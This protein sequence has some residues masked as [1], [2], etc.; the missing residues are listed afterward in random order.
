MTNSEQYP[1]VIP[2]GE[3]VIFV[4][5]V[6]LDE[7]TYHFSDK[8]LDRANVITLNV[9][10]FAN[11]RSLTQRTPVK[12]AKTAVS[13]DLFNSYQNNNRDIEMKE[14]ELALLWEIHS[15]LQKVNKNL[16]AGP[17]IVRQIDRYL[18]NLPQGS[19]F[20]RAEAFDM[21]IV[22]RILTKVRG[23]EDQLKTFIGAYDRQTDNIEDS[24]LGE[25]L[26]RYQEVSDFYETTNVL[27]SKAKELKLNGY[28]L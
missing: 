12:K 22:Q 5:T 26:T 1:A 7:S 16:G 10:P 28:T 11:L 27:I 21:Q 4:G 3:N 20:T 18:K 23:P 19:T 24:K 15:E 8:V 13:F 2:I 17:R 14:N 6:N 9:L 25:I